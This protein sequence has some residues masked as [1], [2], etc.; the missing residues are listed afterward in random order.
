ES[1]GARTLVT[2]LLNQA[3]SGSV[4]WDILDENEPAAA[5]AR[6]LGF[7]PLRSLTRMRLGP[8]SV[9]SQVGP[10]YAIADPAIG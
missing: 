5:A 2:S 8:D 6:R 10:Q 1:D 9:V 4:L 3:D 7:T